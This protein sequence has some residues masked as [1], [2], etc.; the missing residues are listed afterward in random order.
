MILALIVALAASWVGTLPVWVVRKRRPEN[1]VPAQ[2]GAMALRL[3][4]ILALGVTVSLVARPQLQPF[5]LWLVIA[6]AA[7]LIPDTLFARRIVRTSVE[8]EALTTADPPHPSP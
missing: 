4:T 6:H 8:R 7:L 5:M 1:L 2:L 3:A